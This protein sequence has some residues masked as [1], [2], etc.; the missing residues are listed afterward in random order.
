MPQLTFP[1][2][3]AG[4]AVPVWV[5]LDRKAS[6]ARLRAGQPIPPPV[7]ARGLLDTGSDVTAVLSW[8]LQRLSI[9]P[10]TT[11]STYTAGGS[12]T[13]NLYEVSLS[14]TDPSRPAPLLTFGSLLVSELAAVL[15]D[16]DVLVGLD[17]LLQQRLVLEGP[18]RQFTLEF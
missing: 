15:P 8:V 5:G 4:L 3:A 17:V 11:T 1:V 16:A 6:T 14:I 9:P 18:G 10:A 12:V 7:Q 13:V 2:T